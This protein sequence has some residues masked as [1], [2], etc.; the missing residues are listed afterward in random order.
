MRI[1]NFES[2]S[3]FQLTWT[4][5]FCIFIHIKRL[6]IISYLQ[7]FT[8]FVVHFAIMHLILF[9]VNLN[10]GFI[11]TI[12]CINYR[13]VVRRLWTD[14]QD[15]FRPLTLK[16]QCLINNCYFF[17]VY[18]APAFYLIWKVNRSNFEF[19]LAQL[20]YTPQSM[21]WFSFQT[22]ILYNIFNGKLMV[23]NQNLSCFV[24]TNM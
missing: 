20:E 4:V 14:C 13:F 19:S 7:F 10:E 3:L 17:K 21:S 8:F 11:I 12:F 2:C 15:F 9:G 16:L 6:V 24:V 5:F 23:N 18:F 22:F 1:D